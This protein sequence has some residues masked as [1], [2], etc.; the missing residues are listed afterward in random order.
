MICPAKARVQLACPC[1][2]GSM[3]EMVVLGD[4]KSVSIMITDSCIVGW[5]TAILLMEL[6]VTALNQ[7][8]QLFKHKF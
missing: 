5:S 6:Y 1:V 7:L 3:K 2:S 8:A 4:F